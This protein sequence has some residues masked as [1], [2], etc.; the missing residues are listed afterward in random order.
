[1]MERLRKPD[2]DIT[3]LASWATK[4]SMELGSKKDKERRAFDGLDPE[5]LS[6][7]GLGRI[8]FSKAHGSLQDSELIGPSKKRNAFMELDP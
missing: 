5:L 4:I 6:Y 8:K 7:I 2:F 3:Q 1:M